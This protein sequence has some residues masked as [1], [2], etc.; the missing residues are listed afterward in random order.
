[1]VHVEERERSRAWYRAKMASLQMRDL[2]EERSALPKSRKKNVATHLDLSPRAS[3]GFRFVFAPCRMPLTSTSM[4][5]EATKETA[6][7]GAKVRESS[8]NRRQKEIMTHILDK[9]AP[10][11]HPLL[12]F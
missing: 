1:M 9:I 10:P 6:A 3:P 11:P 2:R 4:P 8:S 7:R 12:H 5:C